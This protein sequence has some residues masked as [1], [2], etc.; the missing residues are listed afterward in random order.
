M[1]ADQRHGNGLTWSR[2]GK[3]REPGQLILVRQPPPPRVATMKRLDFIRIAAGA[4]IVSLTGSLPVSGATPGDL[5]DR[6]ARRHDGEVKTREGGRFVTAKPRQCDL[7][8]ALQELD[9][10]ADASLMCGENRVSGTFSGRPFVVTL[11]PVS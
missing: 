8:A 10:L 1:D 5:L 9:E 3:R 4:S 6:W 11:A 2:I 7:G